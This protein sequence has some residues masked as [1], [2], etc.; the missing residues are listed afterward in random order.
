MLGNRLTNDPKLNFIQLAA[1]IY[2]GVVEYTADPANAGRIKVRV[3]G[4]NNTDQLVDKI[5]WLPWAIPCFMPGTFNVP[6]VGDRVL[7]MFR[8]ND[9]R[10]PVYFGVMYGITE[11]DEIK[12]R[13]PN[14]DNPDALNTE[15]DVAYSHEFS[16]PEAQNDISY[17]Q[18]KG[19]TSPEESYAKRTT[20]E[21]EVRVI[22]KTRRGH[23]IYAV[24]E[25][26]KEVF[27]IIDR[28][29]QALSFEGAAVTVLDGES[30]NKHN[31]QRRGLRDI[32]EEGGSAVP[33]KYAVNKTT[34][35]KLL[36]AKGQGI[37]MT[38]SD[39]PGLSRV[40]ILGIPGLGITYSDENG[41]SI[42]LETP[43]G[44]SISIGEN[45]TMSAASGGN[46]SIIGGK[47]NLNT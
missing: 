16:E 47:V 13:R 35:V 5:E 45:I 9:P 19:N 30:V 11:K 23:T 40:E 26:E 42:K 38:A 24:D 6:E 22:A 12:G 25:S 17:I 44:S 3:P 31:M 18:A 10:R 4:I 1:G 2:E 41:G 27:K 21:P 29:G 15:F 28:F 36:D 46:I 43:Q 32:T 34:R 39:I 7:V 33:L 8:K 20:Q 37:K 14:F